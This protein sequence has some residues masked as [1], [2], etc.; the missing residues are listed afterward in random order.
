M[1]AFGVVLSAAF[2]YFNMFE[3][4]VSRSRG[5]VSVGLLKLSSAHSACA[6]FH[7]L[8]EAESS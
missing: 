7:L 3:N 6:I 2:T 4:T 8:Q 5:D 1:K